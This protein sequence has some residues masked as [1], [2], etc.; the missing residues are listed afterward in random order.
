MLDVLFWIA[1]GAFIGWNVPQPGY[2]KW[3]QAWVVGK[4]NSFRD[5]KKKKK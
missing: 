2:A 5:R 1:V 3:L 4:V